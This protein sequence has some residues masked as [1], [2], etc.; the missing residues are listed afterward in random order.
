MGETANIAG[1]KVTTDE[2]QQ[3]SQSFELWVSNA[4]TL[5]TVMRE[6]SR[7]KGVLSVDRVRG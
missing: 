2:H 7:V 6:I 4:K 5:T 1:V 3:A